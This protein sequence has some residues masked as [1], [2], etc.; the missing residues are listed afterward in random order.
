M[1][2]IQ[3]LS[4]FELQNCFKWVFYILNGCSMFY[5]V[6]QEAKK[7]GVRIVE[8]PLSYLFE[9]IVTNFQSSLQALPTHHIH[10]KLNNPAE[11]LN[12]LT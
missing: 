4:L 2:N 5:F 12:P 7:R 3:K 6:T 10:L 9:K 8:T 1:N 11:A